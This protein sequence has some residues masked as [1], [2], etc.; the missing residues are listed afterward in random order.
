MVITNE[1]RIR[2]MLACVLAWTAG[3]CRVV[4]GFDDLSLGETAELTDASPGDAVTEEVFTDSGADGPLVGDSA[5]ADGTA[6]AADSGLV[7][8]PNDGEGTWCQCCVGPYCGRKMGASC[9]YE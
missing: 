1:T 2:V 5:P 7:Y 3:A 6:D 9:A 4:G 8:C